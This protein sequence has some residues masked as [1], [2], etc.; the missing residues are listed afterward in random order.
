M[1]F[2][3]SENRFKTFISE[4]IDYAGKH[5]PGIP[6]MHAHVDMQTNLFRNWEFN[7]V[8][9]F[10]GKQYLNDAN[11]AQTGS[12]QTINLR[13]AYTIDL[14]KKIQVQC[15][16]HVNNLLNEHYASMVL[17]NAPSFGGRAPR[18][19]YPGMPR[20]FLFTIRLAVK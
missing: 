15:V 8:Y 13:S 20:N 18:Y 1:L 5:L 2:R 16:V 12:W 11:T 3:S 9:T 6:E 7:A 10:S 14:G 4:D 19:Y 17:I